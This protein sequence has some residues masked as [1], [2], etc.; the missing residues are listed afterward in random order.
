MKLKTTTLAALAALAM[1]GAAS[2]AA[3]V[4][5]SYYTTTGGTTDTSWVNVTGYNSVVAGNA[6][7]AETTVGLVTW[8][9]L[10]G[11]SATADGVTIE[12]AAYGVAWTGALGGFYSGTPALLDDAAYSSSLQAGSVDH[13]VSLTGLTI[14]KAYKVQFVMADN[15]DNTGLATIFAKTG[16]SGDSTAYT[17]SYTSGEFAVITASFIADGT[18]ARFQPQAKWGTGGTPAV[19][20]NAVQ[21]LA[22]PEP[23]AAL[24][25]GLGMLVLLRR[26]R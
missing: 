3:T 18:E 13:T 21:V 10:N 26:R 5:Y 15:R 19:F 11:T 4:S 2:A 25:G 12:V 9:A 6:G 14:G 1:A 20:V 8:K 7:G 23:G 16:V 22:I 24:L 17:Y